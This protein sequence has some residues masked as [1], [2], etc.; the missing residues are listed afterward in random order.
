MSKVP[1]S[2]AKAMTLVGRPCTRSAVS[3]PA[4][5]AAPL[6]KTECSHGTRQAVC[7]QG[8]VNTSRQPV[9]F[10]TITSGPAASVTSRAARA[11]PQP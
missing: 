7:G 3:M 9:A 4:A 1:P 11:W 8:V 10:A 5:I 2:P 6:A